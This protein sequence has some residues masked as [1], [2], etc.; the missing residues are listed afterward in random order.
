MRAVRGSGSLHPRL[1]SRRGGLFLATNSK[2]TVDIPPARADNLTIMARK[3]KQTLTNAVDAVLDARGTSAL[4]A[5]LAALAV[6]R[7]QY[8]DDR[9]R[10][11]ALGSDR[12]GRPR[13]VSVTTVRRLLASGKSVTEIAG[14]L[15]CGK[16]TVR[17]IRAAEQET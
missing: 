15:G 8:T 10:A 16:T 5:A 6:A 2:S 9:R 11:A 12:A 1:T 13:E 17:R 7:D 3:K 4:D 14:M